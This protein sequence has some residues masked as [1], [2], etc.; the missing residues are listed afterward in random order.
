MK[1]TIFDKPPDTVNALTVALQR[2]EEL[3]AEVAHLTFCLESR[4][5]F[6][7]DRGLWMDYV[8][9]LPQFKAGRP[10]YT[11]SPNPPARQS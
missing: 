1:K 2:I 10:G 4:D 5:Q 7:G 8:K 11:W 9:T 6:I 3:R